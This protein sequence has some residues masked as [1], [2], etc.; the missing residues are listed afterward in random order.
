MQNYRPV[1][2]L[3]PAVKMLLLLNVI[4]YFLPSLLGQNVHDLFYEKFCLH[5]P[6]SSYWYPWQY[7]THMFLHA[8]IS[9]LFFNMFAV[10]MFGR[11]LE[12][13]WGSK[14]FLI[15]YF[16]CGIGAGIL[17]SAIGWFE[18]QE[19]MKQLAEFKTNPT[20]TFFADVVKEQIAH[21][22]PDLWKF[23]DAW[24][25]EPN[26]PQLIQQGTFLFQ[27][28]I[29]NNINGAML[30]ASGAVFGILLAFGMLFPNTPLYLMF[31]PIP[32]KA[33]YFVIGYGLIE[34]Y[35][36]LQNNPADNIAHFAHLGGMLFGFLLLKFWNRNRRKFY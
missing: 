9:H 19:L 32:I 26:S 17:N 34:I 35:L 10:F 6:Q 30:G 36:G 15:Y 18:V 28:I 22:H 33:K 16:V 1:L 27:K 14:R 31:I 21:P 4:M 5:L 8:D 12:N 25:N 3:T 24:I 2:G 7:I 29:E 13:I 20:P 23:I 11:I